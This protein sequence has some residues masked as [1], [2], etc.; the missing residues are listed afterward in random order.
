MLIEGKNCWR[1]T[2]ADRAAFLVDG[3]AYFDAFARAALRARSSILIVGWDFNS[4]TRLWAGEPPM[5]VPA[6][7]GDFLDF[8]ARRKRKLKIHVLDWDFPMMYAVNREFPPIFGL[9]WQPRRNIRL[10]FDCNFPIG[11]SQHQKIVVIDNAM[12]FVGGIDFATDRWDTPQH[13]A[14]DMRRSKGGVAYPPVHD[15]MIAVDGEAARALGEL[16][17]E[18]WRRATGEKLAPV[19]NGGDPWPQDLVPDLSSITV[20]ISRTE[21]GYGAWREVREVETLYVDM[22]SA[23]RK[24]VY[25]E[26]QYFSS[27]R[28]G[29]A[30]EERLQ[31]EDSPEI[32]LVLRQCSDGW[33]EGPTMGM[34]RT[35]LLERLRRADRFGRLHVFY[36]LVPGLE[37]NCINVHAKLCIV[38]DELVR[39]GSA[40]LN[41]RSMGL[42]TECDVTVEAAGADAVCRAIAGFR[43]RLLAEHLGTDPH[44]VENAMAREGSA[45]A[46]IASL[47]QGE[48]RLVPFS[49]AEA[50]PVALAP[51]VE[52][53]DLESPVAADQFITRLVPCGPATKSSHH[54]SGWLLVLLVL[55]GSVLF[56]AFPTAYGILLSA[57][58][59]PASLMIFALILRGVAFE[60]RPEAYRKGLWSVSL[61]AGSTLAAFCQGAMLGSFVQGLEVNGQHF[62]GGPWDWLTPFSMMSGVAVVAGYALLGAAWLILKTEGALQAYCYRLAKPLTIVLLIFFAVVGI[63][64]PLNQPAIAARW[65]SMPT[66]FWLAPMPLASVLA[67]AGLWLSLEK[68]RE[69]VPF[70]L[71]VALFL[72]ALAGFA[73]SLWPYIVPRT[74]T[75]WEAAAPPATL[76]FVLAG[77]LILMPFVLGYTVHTYRLFRGKTARNHG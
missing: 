53:A 11:G 4:R 18:R 32:I 38:D 52:L 46:A 62:T 73:Y 22:I 13:K 69:L 8:L 15:V 23:A 35:Q 17:S 29:A 21:P 16:A 66:I 61:V 24:L 59:V 51:I 28:I 6:E 27:A 41:N 31:Q 2:H 47:S 26:N 34:L 36:P 9:I 40:N 65:F 72:L 42:D 63:W 77:V 7:L 74:F 67:G 71:A 12:A 49:E 48:R 54:L 33:L 70:M 60:Y 37:N 76:G 25:I 57:W 10:R 68:R 39:V 30:I 75:L 14:N 1:R 5:D 3:A 20:G 44:Q 50:W 43:N 55:G 19:K 58:Y 64:T 56:A 45:A